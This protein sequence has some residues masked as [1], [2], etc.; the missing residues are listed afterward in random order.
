MNLTRLGALCGAV[1]LLAA[2]P[3]GAQTLGEPLPEDP[4][5]ARMPVQS[6]VLEPGQ[7]MIL[8]L[9]DNQFS[10]YF[11]NDENKLMAPPVDFVTVRGFYLNQR[12]REVYAALEPAEGGAYLTS[13]RVVPPPHDL[14]LQLVVPQGHDTETYEVIGEFGFNADAVKN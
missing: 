10:V 12:D 5:A 1:G 14:R 7:S 9:K 13:P 6:T 4:A 3:L 8:S 2:L 11:L